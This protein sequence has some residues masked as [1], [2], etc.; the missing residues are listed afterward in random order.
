MSTP[1]SPQ[2]FCV[3]RIS[4]SSLWPR[5]TSNE[6]WHPFTA[7]DT[8]VKGTCR[9][10]SLIRS[11]ERNRFQLDR[12][13]IMTSASS[14]ALGVF[15]LLQRGEP[16]QSRSRGRQTVKRGRPFRRRQ[17]T[18]RSLTRRLVGTK[19]L[20]C[21]PSG[22]TLEAPSALDQATPPTVSTKGTQEKRSSSASPDISQR[23]QVHGACIGNNIQP[24]IGTV[25]VILSPTRVSIRL[26][27]ERTFSRRLRH[28]A[29]H[30]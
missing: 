11:A 14:S 4:F 29:S 24:R 19:R 18:R 2:P 30:P 21:S 8:V 26:D 5:N 12:R 22:A 1:S 23:L 17:R 10:T 16:S 25:V 13:P 6:W 15:K 28:S 20:E 7:R 27:V 9:K 3:L